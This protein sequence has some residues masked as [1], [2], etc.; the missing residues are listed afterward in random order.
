M[1][2][3]WAMVHV[4]VFMGEHTPKEGIVSPSSC[5]IVYQNSID[6]ASSRSI[7]RHS[8]PKDRAEARRKAGRR[9]EIP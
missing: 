4:E 1:G 6:Y 8:F 3:H 5:K 2:T 9:R 7:R